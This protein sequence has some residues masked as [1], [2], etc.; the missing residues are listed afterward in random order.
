MMKQHT[1][2]LIALVAGSIGGILLHSE[3]QAEWLTLLSTHV[4]GPIGQIFLRLIFMVVVPMVFSALLLGVYELGSGHGLKRVATKTLALTAIASSASVLIGIILVNVF[5][6]GKGLQTQGLISDTQGVAK[7][8]SNA[9]STK[10][11]SQLLVDIIPKNP[12]DS[13]VRA[14][15]GEMVSLMFFALSSASLSP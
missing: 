5:Q 12:L 4:L 7:I 13:A 2:L 14:L 1:K 6:P 3:T 10:P 9:S 8:Q 11:F 15:D